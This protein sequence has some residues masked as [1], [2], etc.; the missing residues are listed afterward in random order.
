M[1]KR[2]TTQVDSD[3]LDNAS[4]C[5]VTGSNVEAGPSSSKKQRGTA[6][7]AKK[8]KGKKKALNQSTDEWPEYFKS[9]SS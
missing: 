5:G 2:K 4:D 7:N 6:T 8:G 9:V 1:A 3:D